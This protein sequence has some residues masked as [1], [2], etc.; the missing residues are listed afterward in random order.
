MDGIAYGGWRPGAIAQA[1]ALHMDYYAPN[2]GFGLQFESKLAF[3]MGEF[4]GRFDASRDL[5]L[6]AWAPDGALVATISVD[7]RD[8]G[9]EGAHLRWFVASP[10]VRG[11]GVGGELMRRVDAF[12]EERGH[13][14]AY[15]T[16]FAGLDAA[17]ALYDRHG[18]EL[19]AE[20]KADPWL[21]TVG[22]QRFERRR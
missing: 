5:F 17:R 11:K 1:L 7:G 22:L 15:L 18:Y 13:R 6:G 14:R 20:E 16:T 12:L 8:A 21:G 4:H 19:V 2:W 3:E 10:R 9:G